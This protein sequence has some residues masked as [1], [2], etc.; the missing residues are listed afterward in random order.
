ME[1]E[2][3]SGH[4]SSNVLVSTR[5]AQS[6]RRTRLIATLSGLFVTAACMAPREAPRVHLPVQSDPDAILPVTNAEGYQISLTEARM[7][8]SDF[9]F[10]TAGELHARSLLQKGW[11]LLV[12]PAWAHP[13]HYQGGELVGELDGRFVV[14]VLSR[15]LIGEGEFITSKYEAA[16]FTF[17]LATDQEVSPED[18]LLGHSALLRGVATKDDRSIEFMVVL[19][20]PQDRQLV[21]APFPFEITEASKSTVGFQFMLTDPLEG[22]T[23]F[24]GLDFESIDEDQDGEIEIGPTSPEGPAQDAYVSLRRTFMTHDHYAFTFEP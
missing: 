6:M 15:D 24:D 12:P 14:D 16:N 9:Q 17:D 18:P 1:I 19:D 5:K 2:T 20:A 4:S 22:D 8:L 13:G 3:E 10:T 7:A 23:F 11:A 21:G